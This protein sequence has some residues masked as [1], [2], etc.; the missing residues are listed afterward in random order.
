M[1]GEKHPLLFHSLTSDPPVRVNINVFYV[2]Y[3]TKQAHIN[4]TE[5]FFKYT[6]QQFLSLQ[7]CK[8]SAVT[9]V[10]L[11]GLQ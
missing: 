1:L 2:I 3:L 4:L 9:E 5:H 10:D 11:G 6:A 8:W 7:E